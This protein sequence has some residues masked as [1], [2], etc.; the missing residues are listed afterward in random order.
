MLIVVCAPPWHISVAQ[1]TPSARGLPIV[2]GGLLWGFNEGGGG[3][4][5]MVVQSELP[6]WNSKICELAILGRCGRFGW[7]HAACVLALP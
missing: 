1:A 3:G 5:S 4:G 7:H 2:D 6:S